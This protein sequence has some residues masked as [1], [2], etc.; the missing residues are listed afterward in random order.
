MLLMEKT[1]FLMLRHTKTSSK[2]RWK[3]MRQG[4][5]NRHR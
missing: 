1:K 5:F 3:G 2:F 4:D